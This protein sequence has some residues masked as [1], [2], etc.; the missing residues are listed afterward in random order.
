MSPVKPQIFNPSIYAAID[1]PDKGPFK[2]KK[3][4]IN[5]RKKPLDSRT[6]QFQFMHGT[7]QEIDVS[8]L[9]I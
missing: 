3:N 1:S 7:L 9:Y 5:A 2:S 8:D 6:S 4:A